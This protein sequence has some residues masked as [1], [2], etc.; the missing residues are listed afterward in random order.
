MKTLVKSVSVLTVIVGAISTFPVNAED[1]YLGQDVN[2][3]YD[4]VDSDGDT[5]PDVTEEL[6][7]TDPFDAS[8]Y[9]GSEI[10][11]S[12][13]IQVKSLSKD[14]IASS[15]FPTSSCRSGFRQAGA[16]LCISTNAQNATRYDAAAYRCRA[17]RARVA[18]YEDLIYLYV[19]TSLD[20]TYNPSG[21]WIG[22]MVGNDAVMYGD[23]SITY[24]NDPDIWN[25]EGVANKSN[26]RSY[27]CAHDDE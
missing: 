16:R 4:L 24:N 10:D 1:T 19:Y 27:W 8:D 22:N 15:G 2:H 20:A 25:F 11:S 5:F 13:D 7:G 9:P 26:S 21:K 6:G 23:K 17:K 14:Q 18:T 3:E 12:A